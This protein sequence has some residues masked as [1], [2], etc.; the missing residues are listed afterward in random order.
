[1]LEMKIQ[2]GHFG[3]FVTMATKKKIPRNLCPVIILVQEY[4]GCSYLKNEYF[5]VKNAIEVI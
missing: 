4:I 3:L 5:L 2:S 1:M